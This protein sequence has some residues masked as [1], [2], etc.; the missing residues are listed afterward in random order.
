[1]SQKSRKTD[2]QI[3]KDVIAYIDSYAN[4]DADDIKDEHILKKAPLNLDDTM[5]GFL[6]L[7]LRAYVKSLNGK[8]TVLVTELRKKDLSVK[9]TY[10]LVIEKVKA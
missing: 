7:S 5:L 10:E 1:M 2:E 3:K 6:A 4:L 8:E 9:Q